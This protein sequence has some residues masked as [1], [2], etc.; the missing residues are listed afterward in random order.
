M[1]KMVIEIVLEPK[2]MDILS[3]L[4]VIHFPLW[5]SSI[6]DMLLMSSRKYLVLTTEHNKSRRNYYPIT[7]AASIMA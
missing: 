5:L 3:L 6:L 4:V 1:I 2:D 7:S